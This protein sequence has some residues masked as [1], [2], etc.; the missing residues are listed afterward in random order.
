LRAAVR[1]FTRTRRQG[2]AIQITLNDGERFYLAT[3]S[4]EGSLI[5]L[6]LYPEKRELIPASDD[7]AFA[8]SRSVVLVEPHVIA[9]TELL[10]DAPEERQALGFGVADEA[11]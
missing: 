3:S 5:A 7:T 6:H 8:Y 11:A 2:P 4:I 10:Y 1:E 9:K